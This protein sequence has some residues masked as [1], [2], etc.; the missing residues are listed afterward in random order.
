MVDVL[1]YIPRSSKTIF[2][3]LATGPLPTSS[4]RHSLSVPPGILL[5]FEAGIKC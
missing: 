5:F 4:L 2:L 3:D 1:V